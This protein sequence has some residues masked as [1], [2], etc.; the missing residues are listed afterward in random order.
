MVLRQTRFN[1][2]SMSMIN[3]KW[4]I[5]ILFVVFYHFDTDYQFVL[6]WFQNLLK[7]LN[8]SFLITKF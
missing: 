6:Y 2:L 4:N 3:L 5:K 7:L 1:L 8:K